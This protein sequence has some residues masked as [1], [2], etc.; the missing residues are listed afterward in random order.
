MRAVLVLG[1]LL[2]ALPAAAAPPTVAVSYFDNN[3]GQPALAPLAKGLCDMLITDLGATGVLQV[4]EREKLE[5]ALKE[6]ALSRGT[7]IDPKTAL[8]LG[9]GLAARYLLTGG[10]TLSGEQLR[11][12]V[13]LFNVETGK[14]LASEKVEG[15][16]DEFFALEK[17]LVDVLVAALELKLDREAKT[18]LRKNPTQSFE[19]WSRYAEGLDARDR[20]DAA[21]ARAAFEKALAADPGYAAARTALERLAAIFAK[22]DR[23]TQAFADAELGR[24][25]PKA[26]GFARS[27]EDLL[28]KLDWGKLEQSKRKTSLLLWLGQEKLLACVKTA[29]AAPESPHVLVDG[30]PQGGVISH[31]RQAHEVLLIAY[32]LADDPTLWGTLPR[33]CEAL[34]RRLPGDRALLS[35]CENTLVPLVKENQAAGAAAGTVHQAPRMKQML[36]RYA[37]W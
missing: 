4:V 10:Y 17:E 14:V 8:K 23:D 16:K 5:Q 19:A 6:L 33:V 28:T 26:P 18:R 36:E 15:K 22:A 13:R 31:C 35:Y 2:A 20:G 30:V 32:E 9:K 1:L 29:G 21:R 3:T 37:G 12:D 24:L 34:I 25:D 7:F 27:V 11:I